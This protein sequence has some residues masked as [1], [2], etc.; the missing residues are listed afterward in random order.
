MKDR[1]EKIRELIKKYLVNETYKTFQGGNYIGEESAVEA[2]ESHLHYHEEEVP[3]SSLCYYLKENG[4]PLT[5]ADKELIDE[6]GESL[7]NDGLG[8][9]RMETKYWKEIVE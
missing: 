8:Q 7:W 4:I 5:Q 1:T 9:Y 3:F 6:I 2:N